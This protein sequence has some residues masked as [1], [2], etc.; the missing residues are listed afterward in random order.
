M[1][2]LHSQADLANSCSTHARPES[3]SS[4]AETAIL[5]GQH[6]AVA[7]TECEPAA[8]RT[9][10]RGAESHRGTQI[11]W[12]TSPAS[13]SKLWSR[14]AASFVTNI[15][16]TSLV[17]H[18]NRLI[19]SKHPW[20]EFYGRCGLWGEAVRS[21]SKTIEQI[22][23]EFESLQKFLTTWRKKYPD[24]EDLVADIDKIWTTIHAV[25]DKGFGEFIATKKRQGPPTGRLSNVRV[26][27]DDSRQ[28]RWT[29][30]AAQWF[31]SKQVGGIVPSEGL[32]DV[33]DNAVE[34]GASGGGRAIDAGS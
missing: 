12:G 17:A 25:N 34:F 33:C 15:S 21:K 24:S 7:S 6:S 9:A 31:C 2:R 18:Y 32:S 22:N 3:H 10:R 16:R 28:G 5:L 19:E 27:A 23:A 14:T 20:G 1:Q 4:H 29:I 8:W 26:V 30:R 11:T 13:Q